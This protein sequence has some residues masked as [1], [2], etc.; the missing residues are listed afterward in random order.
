M[1]SVKGNQ[2]LV[3]YFINDNYKELKFDKL[4]HTID[5]NVKTEHLSAISKL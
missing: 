4:F 3:K 5:E 2:D 1:S